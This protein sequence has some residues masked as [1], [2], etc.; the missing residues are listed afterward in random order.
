MYITELFGDRADIRYTYYDRGTRTPHFPTAEMATEGW[1]DRESGKLFAGVP[2]V[3]SAYP[4]LDGGIDLVIDLRERYFV[5]H[6]TI[7][8]VGGSEIAALSVLDA[9]GVLV[10][11]AGPTEAN[12]A[13]PCTLAIGR[14]TNGL[15]LRLEAC[16]C[17]VGI[18]KIALYAAAGLE[19]TVYP[20]PTSATY[21]EGSLPFAALSGIR[22]EDARAEGAAAYLAERFGEELGQSL[23]VG[24]GNVRFLY[25]PRTDDGYTLTVN[26]EGVTV[27]AAEVRAFYYA[28]A[29]LM[30]LATPEGLRYAEIDDT[31]FMAI[32]GVHLSLPSRESIP[33]FYRLFR[34]LLVPMRYNM[35]ILQLS[36]AM[37]YDCYPRIN[38]MWQESG[39]RYRAGE[40]PRP[41]HYGFVPQDVLTHGEVQEICAYVRSFGLEIV[42][43]VQSLSH[44]QY[45][46]T[47]YP[48]IAETKPKVAATEID[49][50]V[51][52]IPPADFYPHNACP[53]HPRYY[54]YFLPLIDEVIDVIR[55]ERYLHI[56][57]DEGYDIGKCPRCQGKAA[58]VFVEEVTRLHDHLAKHGLGTMMWSDMLHPGNDEYLV[59][60]AAPLLPKDIVMLDFTWYF[61]IPVDIEDRLL[62]HGYR[63]M[64]GN[65]YSSHYPRYDTRSKKPGVI[66]AQISTWTA[67]EESP[68]AY[69]GKFYDFVYTATMMWNPD[70]DPACRLTYAEP[71]KRLLPKMR[72]RIGLLPEYTAAR[73]LDIGAAPENVPS[74]LLYHSPAT[75]ALRLSGDAPT[76][77]I[78]VG[79]Q[80]EYLEILHATDKNSAR[81]IWELGIEIG[82]Y[83]LIYEDG[84]EYA[85][86]V[87]Y[88]EH[89]LTYRHRYGTPI[90]SPYY[91]HSGYVATYTCFPVEGKDAEGRDY[92]LLRYPIVNPHPE[93]RIERILCRHH[94]NT[95]AA[96]LVFAIKTN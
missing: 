27:A 57:H 41:A 53:R 52:D 88:S 74:A 18:Q 54:D 22:I 58:E 95:D 63:V 94:G 37:Q 2:V 32:R 24:E 61:E 43:E 73:T 69:R 12:G 92:T 20:R 71:V 49:Q 44:V 36:G 86:P 9:D 29:T 51:A 40:W 33:F 35:V 4:L 65:M 60:A 79:R 68:L 76:A 78:T 83:R 90:P 91:R 14:Y 93:K 16:F 15:T 77:E 84:S 39:R 21:G 80:A 6:M 56:G 3:Y 72:H 82:E 13:R 34:E 45:V 48:E 87:R 1:L 31:P 75:A 26:A 8:L 96:I 66:G 55:P 7:T 23:T 28:A 38:E 70:Y 5:D 42:P 17:H 64:F 30:Q 11:Q 47:A 59:P 19:D 46:T 50:A 81:P 25:A 89:I 10:A 62:P 85:A 67:N